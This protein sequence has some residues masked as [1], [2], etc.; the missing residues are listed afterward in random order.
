MRKTFTILLLFSILA[1][2]L[3]DCATEKSQAYYDYK[4]KVIASEL[5]GSYT[6][7]AWGRARYASDAYDQARKQALR[8]VI[9]Y[10]VESSTSTVQP[11]KPLIFE[12]NAEEKYEAYFNDF[13]KYG[14][15]YTKYSS[16]IKEKRIGS[17]KFAKN[18]VQ[19]IAEVTVSV[20]R[21][22]LKEK[23]QKDGILK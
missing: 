7:R 12:V 9:F 11:L 19:C 22:K 17:S 16:T 15:E 10:G 5:D 8:D 3:Y 20:D 14:G 1:L 21:Q 13:F 4:S 6:I 23:L 18:E 2:S